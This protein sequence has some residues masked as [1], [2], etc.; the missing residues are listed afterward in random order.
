MHRKERPYMTFEKLRDIICAHFEIEP[1]TV[2]L[3]SVILDDFDAD[4]LDLVDL[5]MDIEDEFNVEIPDDAIETM[6]T[7]GDVV[8]YIDAHM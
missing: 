3:E 6:V 1:E 7:V 8:A 5:S 4:S 2:K